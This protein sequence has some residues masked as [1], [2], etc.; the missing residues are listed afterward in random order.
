MSFPLLFIFVE[1]EACASADND[2]PN[3]CAPVTENLRCGDSGGDSGGVL[4][5]RNSGSLPASDPVA[6]LD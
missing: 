2:G 4:G 5:L 1:V 3:F 6:L